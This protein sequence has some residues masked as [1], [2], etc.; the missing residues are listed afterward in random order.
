MFLTDS[1]RIDAGEWS[2]LEAAFR[3]GGGKRNT[4]MEDEVADRVLTRGWADMI[5]VDDLIYAQDDR[6]SFVL[7][8]GLVR[9]VGRDMELGEM[10]VSRRP[11]RADPAPVVDRAYGIPQL[12]CFLI[13]MS[14]LG[15]TIDA[16]RFCAATQRASRD[17]DWMTLEERIACDHLSRRRAY[18]PVTLVS[19]SCRWPAVSRAQESVVQP[20][21]ARVSMFRDGTGKVARI[22]I[23]TPNRTRERV[24]DM[25]AS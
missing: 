22:E 9:A 4:R 3:A 20:S 15:F 21:G 7:G 14:R 13:Q 11:S 8:A 12:S 17:R 10:Y 1:I 19:S 6:L 23:R 16:T 24:P 18:P 25:A 2:E 5:D